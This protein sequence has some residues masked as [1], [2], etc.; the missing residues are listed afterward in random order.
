MTGSFAIFVTGEVVTDIGKPFA[1]QIWY[2][3][4]PYTEGAS[5][6]WLGWHATVVRAFTRKLQAPLFGL[7]EIPRPTLMCCSMVK[8]RIL[9]F[10]WNF[11]KK[12][13]S[14]ED[15]GSAQQWAAMCSIFSEKD[16]Y[17]SDWNEIADWTFEILFKLVAKDLY[18]M[19]SSMPAETTELI[20][21][22]KFKGPANLGSCFYDNRGL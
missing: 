7:E 6:F 18:L 11:S 5:F 14:S 20:C 8:Q 21:T 10:L 1:L 13:S 2:S 3:L 22:R 4:G 9:I 16:E 15:K 19:Y 17:D 12:H